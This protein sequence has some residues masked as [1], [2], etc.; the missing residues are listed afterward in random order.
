MAIFSKY[1]K[2]EKMDISDGEY[3]TIK[4]QIE[5]ATSLPYNHEI[6]PT[7]LNGDVSK[8]N[9]YKFILNVQKSLNKKLFGLKH[10]KQQLLLIL[11]NTINPTSVNIKKCVALCEPPGT[12]KSTIPKA[13]AKPI[14]LQY[15]N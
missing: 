7:E 13:F 15:Y 2:L 5:W 8:R 1:L 11:N 4:N 6:I 9:V 3:S 10:V 14:E 12:G